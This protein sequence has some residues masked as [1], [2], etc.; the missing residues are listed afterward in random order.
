MTRTAYNREY[1]RLNAARLN[2]RRARRAAWRWACWV[3][4]EVLFAPP[5][6]PWRVVDSGRVQPVRRPVLK[7]KRV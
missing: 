3:V 5:E 1:R 2:A 4:H 7:L 6:E